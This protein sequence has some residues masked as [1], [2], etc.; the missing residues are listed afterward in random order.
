MTLK[1]LQIIGSMHYGG[2]E[3]V[4]LHL[5]NRPADQA[6]A[7]SVCCTRFVGS[8]GEQLR[9]QGV[10]VFLTAPRRHAFRYFG[11]M[12][13]LGVIRRLRPD[14]VHTH[15]LQAIGTIGPLAEARLVP[16]WVH[17]FHYGNYPYSNERW[18]WIERT[19]SRRAD[20]LVAVSEAQRSAIIRWH[21]VAARRIEVVPNGVRP[22][23]RRLDATG[24]AELRRVLGIAEDKRIVGTVAVMTEQK[25]IGHLLDAAARIAKVSPDVHFLIVGG[26]PREQEYRELSQSMGLAGVVTFAGWRDD[27]GDLLQLMDI[28]VMSSLWEAMPLALLEAMSAGRPIVATDV[29][30]NAIILDDGRSGLIVPPADP[31]SLAGAIGRLLGDAALANQMGVNA[32]SRLREHYSVELMLRRYGQIYH[33]LVADRKHSGPR[34]R[35]VRSRPD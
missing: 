10:P 23:P 5:V 3:K 16:P 13:L 30:D 1:V 26:G 12:R 25:G 8:I 19:F 34:P 20:R 35:S 6:I 2:A 27:V 21:R 28:Y 15:G 4:V 17:T 14:V 7:T 31:G 32:A 18:M 9:A 24:V 33:E 11:P 29:S 22:M